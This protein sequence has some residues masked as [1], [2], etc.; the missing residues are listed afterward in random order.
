MEQDKLKKIIDD[1]NEDLEREAL[2]NAEGII[3]EISNEQKRV[4][5]SQ[6]RISELRKQLKELSVEQ[7][8]HDDIL[9]LGE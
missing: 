2:R 4:S 9:G 7:L 6:A 8:S 1:R 3:R 5:D